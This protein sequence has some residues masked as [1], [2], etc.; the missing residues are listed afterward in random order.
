MMTELAMIFLIL[1]M[2]SSI[3]YE[4]RDQKVMW[5]QISVIFYIAATVLSVYSMF[6]R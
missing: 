5:L 2:L 4:K 6:K 3:I 1:G